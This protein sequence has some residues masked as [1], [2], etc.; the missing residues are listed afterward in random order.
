MNW[1]CIC[2]NFVSGKR[3]C[4]RCKYVRFRLDRPE[5][6]DYWGFKVGSLP[7]GLPFNLPIG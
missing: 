5:M 3:F 4:P 1:V 6:L 7:D 2:G